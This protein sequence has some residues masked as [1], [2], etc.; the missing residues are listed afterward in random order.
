MGSLLWKPFDT[1]FDKL[2][3]RLE[4]H[5]TLLRDELQIHSLLRSELLEKNQG[6]QDDVTRIRLENMQNEISK[7]R[8]NQSSIETKYFAHKDEG[9]S[10]EAMINLRR[11]EKGMIYITWQ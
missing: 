9:F 10:E 11:I 6:N 2:L 8:K 3:S 4:A 1:R 7:L 5:S